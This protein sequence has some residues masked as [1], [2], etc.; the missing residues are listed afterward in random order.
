MSRHRR[1]Q[2]RR[3][4]TR[5]VRLVAALHDRMAHALPEQMYLPSLAAI[6]L[7]DQVGNAELASALRVESERNGADFMVRFR[8]DADGVSAEVCR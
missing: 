5:V 4:R 7:A 2:Q 3:A 6:A 8:R 1:Q